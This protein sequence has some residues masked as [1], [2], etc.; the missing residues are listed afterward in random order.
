MPARQ[1]AVMFLRNPAQ[2]CSVCSAVLCGLQTE[3]ISYFPWLLWSVLGQHQSVASDCIISGSRHSLSV[4]LNNFSS[5]SAYLPFICYFTIFKIT[6]YLSLFIIILK[7]L[8]M[9]KNMEFSQRA[10]RRNYRRCI[11]SCSNKSK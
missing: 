7:T 10:P 4:N 2:S 11:F 6:M 5:Y 9:K 1:S 8:F 3:E